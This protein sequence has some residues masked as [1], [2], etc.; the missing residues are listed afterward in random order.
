MKI[1]TSSQWT[2]ALSDKEDNMAEM[3]TAATLKTIEELKQELGV[4][5]AVFEG[6]KAAN[7]WKSGRQ[8]EADAFKEACAAFL[9]A[10]VDGRVTDEEAKL[11]T[12]FG[13]M[14]RAGAAMAGVGGAITGLC[15]KTVTATFDTQN[16][17]GELSSLGVKDL[18]AVENA[19][20]SFSDTWAGTSKSDFITAAYDIKSGIA[21]LTDEGVAQFT[22]LAALTGKATKSTT[23]EMGS[24]FATGYGI[25]KG[26]YDDMSDLEFGEMFSAGIATAVKNYKT[27]GS[28]MASAISALGATATNANVP[29]E[30]QLAIMGQLQTTMSGSEAATKYKSFLNQACIGC[31]SVTKGNEMG[32]Y[33]SSS[34]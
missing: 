2:L 14:Q 33:L 30:E 10:P 26:F 25:Y 3:K 32:N 19:A 17:L 23:E 16:A 18:K 28:E 22:E 9:K 7:G 34:A 13:T 27:S 15:M 11:N 21:S 1:E 24:L 5:D 31:G 4:S 8:V 12:A 6:V 20:K 29:L